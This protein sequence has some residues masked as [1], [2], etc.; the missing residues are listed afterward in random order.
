MQY[1]YHCKYLKKKRMNVRYYRCLYYFLFL[2]QPPPP[3]HSIKFTARIWNTSRDPSVC[4]FSF[5]Y[6]RCVIVA[7]VMF[8]YRPLENI[9]QQ[10]IPGILLPLPYH[11]I[12]TRFPFMRR[13]LS[14]FFHC[15][16][17]WW[18]SYKFMFGHRV[19]LQIILWTIGV[20]CQVFVCFR[21]VIFITT[22]Y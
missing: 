12:F 3:F 11:L 4:F 22:W 16:M 8:C 14:R 13:S 17:A 1:R 2:Y 9:L 10:F 21:F 18:Q 20:K 7:Y 6:K 5:L 15:G 19:R